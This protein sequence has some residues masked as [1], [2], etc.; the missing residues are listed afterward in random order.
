MSMKKESSF[1]SDFVREL[2]KR[3]KLTTVLQYKQDATTVKGFPDTIILGPEAVTV[4]IEFKKHKNAKF[5]PGQK[6][7]GER[8]KEHNFLYYCVYPEIADKV[9][10]ELVEIFR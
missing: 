5:Q 4:Y 2:K 8:L 6:E 1:K 3:V 7:W 9:L 10:D